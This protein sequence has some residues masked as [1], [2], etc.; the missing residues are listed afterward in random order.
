MDFTLNTGGQPSLK[1][2][3][4]HCGNIT[5]QTIVAQEVSASSGTPST[6]TFTKCSICDGMALRE[7][8]GDWNASLKPGDKPLSNDIPFQQLWPKAT[9]FSSDVP[10]R[11]R[12]IYDEARLVRKQSPSSFVV[13]LRRAFEA[14][15]KNRQAEGY[16]LN[17][18]IQW[19]IDHGQLPGVFAEMMHVARM[20]GNLGAHDAGQDVTERDAE[21]S[22]QFF[23]AIV[24]YL[25]IAPSLL[26]KVKTSSPPPG[27]SSPIP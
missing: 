1:G 16:T 27:K 21:V 23:R 9:S 8:P 15:V 17:A 2:F 13:Q 12:K 26:E 22:D 11:I 7:H 4:D 19:M 14:L 24:E 25:Y 20:I 3:C 6:Y 10:S 18:Q 5:F